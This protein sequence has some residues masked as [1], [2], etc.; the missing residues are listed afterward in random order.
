M[1]EGSTQANTTLRTDQDDEC[2]A[3]DSNPES[4]GDSSEEQPAPVCVFCDRKTHGA[5]VCTIS[6]H[7]QAGS[8]ALATGSYDECVRLWSTEQ[9]VRPR[10][11]AEVRCLCDNPISSFCEHKWQEAS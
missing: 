2:A 3:S 5:G 11:C 6:P 8:R 7:W 4:K 1:L 10:V 9:L